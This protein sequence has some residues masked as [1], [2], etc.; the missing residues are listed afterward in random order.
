MTL[1]QNRG[2]HVPGTARPKRLSAIGCIADSIGSDVVRANLLSMC[3]KGE[4]KGTMVQAFRSTRVVLPEGVAPATVL[5]EKGRIVAITNWA[6][7]P[8]G[9]AVHDCGSHLLLPGLIDPHVHI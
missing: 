7:L 3:R 9:C 6:D 2:E 1:S 8:N 5:V 4:S